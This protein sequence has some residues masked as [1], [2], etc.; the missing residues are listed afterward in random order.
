MI[1]LSK[2]VIKAQAHF[3]E[4]ARAFISNEITSEEFKHIASP[5]GVYA[6]R[7]QGTYMI[8]PRIFSG[9]L[10]LNTLEALLK[11]SKE[12]GNGSL[13]FT[14]RQDIQIHDLSLEDTI[15][16]FEKFTNIGLV[17]LG[18]GGNSIRNIACSSLSGVS[19]DEVFDVTPH[20][21][22]ATEFIMSLD[23][24]TNLPR[25]YKIAIS[26]SGKDS[27]YAKIS[28]LGF[29]AK[30]QGG[31]KGFELFGAGGL[32]GRPTKGLHLED[33]I[34][35]S[36]ILNRIE[37]MKLLFEDE[38]DR[39]N[40]SKA[41]IRFIRY[42]LGDEQFKELYLEYVRKIKSQ[43]KKQYKSMRHIMNRSNIQ[44]RSDRYTQ[45]PNDFNDFRIIKQKQ[46]DL[47]AI[48]AHPENGDMKSVDLENL[49]EAVKKLDYEVEFRLT[50]SQGIFVRNVR[51]DDV[52][53]LMKVIEVFTKQSQVENGTAC[54]GAGKC[55]VG[56]RDSQKLIR[57]INQQLKELP[58]VKNKELPTIKVSG[59]KNSCGWHQAAQM[60]F[61]GSTLRTANV[62]V[63]AYDLYLGAYA[64]STVNG[65]GKKVGTIAESNIPEFIFDLV[66]LYTESDHEFFDEFIADSSNTFSDLLKQY[67]VTVN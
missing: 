53:M 23:G 65:L 43:R 17:G 51:T 2:N 60:G 63:P 19:Q 50:N 38:G 26:N 25:K 64:N 36:E 42:R 66:S 4:S 8:R 20:A 13:H 55:R 1:E 24:I 7:E 56:L 22:A 61:N 29:I 10:E 6:Q 11:I 47:Y 9:I 39:E 37:A 46:Q 5:M 45:M 33:F 32:G 62:S 57:S 31:I 16:V 67:V 48:Y 12:H 15:E 28:D 18:A 59:C 49:I 40:R 58:L 3:I 34:E 52:E 21:I 30:I 44:G 27:A 54:I 35:E 41:R 14:T